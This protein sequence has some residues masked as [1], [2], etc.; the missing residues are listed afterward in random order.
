MGRPPL[1]KFPCKGQRVAVLGDMLELG[2]HTERLHREVG[3]FAT[4]V[5]P[6]LVLTV[7]DKAGSIG[8]AL[9]EHFEQSGH[10]AV[11][12]CRDAGEAAAELMRELGDGDVVL[13]KGSHGMKLERITQHATQ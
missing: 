12:R 3:A 1:A 4:T 5:A 13:L 7:G 8:D 11:W 9:E 6:D 10:G 2:A